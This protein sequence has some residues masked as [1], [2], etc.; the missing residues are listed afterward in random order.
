[1]TLNNI[2]TVY[3]SLGD[4]RKA[5][6]KLNEALPILRVIGDRSVEGYTLQNIGTVYNSLGEA[7]KALDNFNEALSIRRALGERSE[8]VQTLLGI[9]QVEQKR[10]NLTHARQSLEQAISIVESV[11]ASIGSQELR[12]SF[13]ASRQDFYES[14]IDVLMQ[15]HKQNPAASFDALALVVS[16]RARARSLLELLIEARADIRQGVDSSLLERERSLQQRLNAKAAA[17]VR[18][19]NRKHTP[20][21]ADAAAKEIAAITAE[22]EDVQARIRD[23]SPRYAALTQPQPLTMAE[24]Q[25][26]VLDPDTLLL[27][28]SLGDNASYL[29]VVGQRSITSHQLPKRAEIEAATRRVRELLTAPQPQP[30]DTEAKYQARVRQARESYWPQ[31]AVLSRMLLGPAVSQLGGKRLLIVADGAL[32]YLPFGALPTP[33]TERQGDRETGRQGDG[34][35]GRRREKENLAPSPRRPVA[36]SPSLP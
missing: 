9:A 26:Q 4:M 2:G 31:A 13:F 19:L 14:Y 12:A 24:I 8:E 35:T 23:R 22:Y 10:G 11:R 16:E 6:D 17:Q 29:F 21:Q 18:L 27:E 5:L 7:Q 28:Y 15:M 1:L 34:G 3:S 30:G 32:Q 33:E 36:P 20:E 25:Q